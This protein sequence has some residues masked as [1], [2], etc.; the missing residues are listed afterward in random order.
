MEQFDEPD[1][2]AHVAPARV[3]VLVTGSVDLK[4]EYVSVTGSGDLKARVS[5][6]LR[7]AEIDVRDAGESTSLILELSSAL[8][9]RLKEGT[10]RTSTISP[11]RCGTCCCG[12][13]RP[14]RL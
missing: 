7:D 5:E 11:A 9:E 4:A 10:P 14:W 12:L 13:I 3:R 8:R 1:Y 6:A 2:R